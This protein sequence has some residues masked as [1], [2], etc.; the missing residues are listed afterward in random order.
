[1]P[2]SA[3]LR[4]TCT[5]E[6][7]RATSGEV[8]DVAQLLFDAQQLVVLRDAIGARRRSRLDLSGV[9]RD[10]EIGDGRVLGLAG[11]MRDDRG[12]A[13]RA[14]QLDRLEGL[15]ERADL[16]DLDE[17]RVRDVL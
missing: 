17:N 11:A 16:I 14:R 5:S 13:G 12:V 4:M 10:R 7:E 15:G 2:N 3:R 1:M 6:P 9:R 8:R